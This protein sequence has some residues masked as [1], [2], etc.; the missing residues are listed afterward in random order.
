MGFNTII[1]LAAL[2]GTPSEAEVDVLLEE[3]EQDVH[4]LQQLRD[5][6]AAMMELDREQAVGQVARHVQPL[7]LALAAVHEGRAD[8]R[9]LP[10]A[11]PR[12]R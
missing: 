11:A 12:R 3:Y 2:Q 8:G 4:R 10:R 6:I 7:R 5:E 9:S 1:L